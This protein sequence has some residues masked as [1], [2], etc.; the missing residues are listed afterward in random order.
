MDRIRQRLTGGFRPFCLRT[1]DGHEYAVLHP[2][3]VLIGRHSL[4]ALDA[5]RGSRRSIRCTSSPSRIFLR[6]R[7][8]FP[9]GDSGRGPSTSSP[10]Q[11]NRVRQLPR[12]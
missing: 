8:A 2:E 5:D 10:V 1:S 12:S 11:F 7:T 6:K 4:A 9:S 3:L